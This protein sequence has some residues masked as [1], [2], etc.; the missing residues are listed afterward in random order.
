MPETSDRDWIKAT[1]AAAYSGF[2][3]GRVRQQF[4]SIAA[5]VEADSSALI[6]AGAT[7][8][9][10]TV[11]Q[12][13]PDTLCDDAER[14]LSVAGHELITMDDATYPDA[15]RTIDGAP[16]GLFV[17]GD[18]GLLQHPALAIVGSR[19]PT[20]GGATTAQEFAAHLAG[21][22][23]AIVSGLAAGVD[24]AAHRGALASDGATIA[25]LGAGIDIDY[26]AANRQLA[27]DIR[28]A[29]VVVSE[30]PPGRSARSWQFPARNRIISGLSLG[31]L[32]VEATQRSGSLITARLAGEQGRSVFAIPGSIHNPLARGCHQLIRQGA[33][34]TE[35]IED[36]LAEIGPQLGQHIETTQ[37]PADRPSSISDTQ[38]DADYARVL[39]ALGWD[40]VG[41]DT[42]IDRS[43]LTAAEV[44]SMLLIMEL[45]GDVQSAPGGKYMRA[46]DKQG[47]T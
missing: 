47:S 39:N 29:G 20:A 38:P 23:L 9:Q 28:R 43:G 24:A 42:L 12:A 10:A 4:S 16:A 17:D 6:A 21:A 30:Y 37:A 41:V 22:G 13:V 34:L 26:P 46:G 18:A 7:T 31:T 33:L 45:R 27:S 3:V 40:P 5:M 11:L 1:I 8:R 14:W 32:V 44:S 15:L 2:P 36:V 25:V 19:N 35:S